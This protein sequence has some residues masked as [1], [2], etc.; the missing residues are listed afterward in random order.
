V[1]DSGL[2]KQLHPRP[3]HAAELLLIRYSRWGTIILLPYAHVYA[4][5]FA[6]ITTLKKWPL[7]LSY[8]VRV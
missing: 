7:F 3:P 8:I 6:N 4:A 1:E 2:R 5:S